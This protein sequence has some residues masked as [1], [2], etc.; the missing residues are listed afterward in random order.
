M[1]TEPPSNPMSS[2]EKMSQARGWVLGG[3]AGEGS[4]SGP[5]LSLGMPSGRHLSAEQEADRGQ[6]FPL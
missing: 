5:L 4:G 3:R 2:K 6:I 1:V